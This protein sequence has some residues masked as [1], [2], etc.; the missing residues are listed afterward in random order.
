MYLQSRTFKNENLLV[1][2][3]TIKFQSKSNKT[4]LE[5]YLQEIG[6]NIYLRL[7]KNK[8]EIIYFSEKNK[9]DVEISEG[10]EYPNWNGYSVMFP[11]KNASYFYHDILKKKLIDWKFF[12]NG[13][14]SRLD[15]KFIRELE[16]HEIKLV[17]P[18]LSACL[19]KI[20]GEYK[21]PNV[22]LQNQKKGEILK[23]G[24][25]RTKNYLRLYRKFDDPTNLNFEYEMKGKFLERWTN[26]LMKFQ[27]EEFETKLVLKYYNFI[28]SKVYLEDSF[29]D[30][31]LVKIRP[32][33]KNKL[34]GDLKSH[35][36]NQKQI[37]GFSPIQREKF[38]I[39]LKFLSFCLTLDYQRDS[40]ELDADKRDRIK[41][42]NLTFYVQDFNKYLGVASN[43]YQ[44]KKLVF[45]LEEFQKNLFIDSFTDS[46]FRSIA[47][48]PV[49]KIIKDQN[50]NGRWKVIIFLSEEIF[51]YNYPFGLP[52]SIFKKSSKHKTQVQV[53]IIQQ[54]SQSSIKKVF[55]IEQFFKNYESGLSN[56]DKTNIKKYFIELIED[57]QECEII[58]PK[59]QIISDGELLNVSKLTTQN[60]TKGFVIYEKL[61]F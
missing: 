29:S 50:N 1:D 53:K 41:Y 34:V 52:S 4:A 25:R 35:Y 36:L 20:K 28:K 5:N 51:C 7:E 21:N 59:L 42:R 18:F 46:S 40:L 57:L 48:I 60:I 13:I 54:I 2:F 61:G 58:E 33:K 17:F 55:D 11:G 44:L 56:Q 24:S 38:F 26:D 3:I 47:V 37:N 31:I 9:Y 12:S 22:T 10:F 45:V 27:F 39:F 43:Y 6:F 23:V 30:W 32:F 14:L 8:K 19:S 16:K 15:L 49:L